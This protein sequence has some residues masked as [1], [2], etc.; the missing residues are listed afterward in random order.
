MTGFLVGSR[1][2]F[3]WR[4][5]FIAVRLLLGDLFLENDDQT[6]TWRDANSLRNARVLWIIISVKGTCDGKISRS[7]VS[8]TLTKRPKTR[9]FELYF[10]RLIDS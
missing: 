9:T 10:A 7:K 5:F 8:E 3:R 1:F 2:E 6:M 4:E